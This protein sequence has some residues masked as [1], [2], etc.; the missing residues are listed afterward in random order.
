M[1]SSRI[2]F[3]HVSFCQ[4]LQGAALAAEDE[5]AGFDIRYF[6]D[7]S[8][9]GSDPFAELRDAARATT[10]IRLAVGATNCVTRH[11]SVT[12]NAIAGVHAASGG[13]AI[14]GVARGDSALKVLGQ[15]PQGFA[16]WVQGIELLRSYLHGGGVAVDDWRSIIRWLPDRPEPPVPLEVMCS[17]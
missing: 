3:G 12:A 8:C 15:P 13:R 11:P 17:G 4:P 9:H 1:A 5:A 7:N 6:G 10:R 14:C 16:P 2:Q